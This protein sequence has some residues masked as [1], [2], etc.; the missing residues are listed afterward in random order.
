MEDKR[1]VKV[2]LPLSKKEKKLL[3]KAANGKKLTQFI[4]ENLGLEIPKI[5]APLKNK[6]ALKKKSPQKANKSPVPE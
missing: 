5:G 2:L 1:T 3:L 4:R 6:N